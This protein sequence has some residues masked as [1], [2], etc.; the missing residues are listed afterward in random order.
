MK[1]SQRSKRSLTV[2]QPSKFDEVHENDE[3]GGLKYLYVPRKP[4]HIKLR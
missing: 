2:V 3:L 1:V 4:D